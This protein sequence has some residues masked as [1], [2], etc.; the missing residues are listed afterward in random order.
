[1]R[2]DRVMLLGGLC[3]VCATALGA[4]GSDARATAD[5]RSAANVRLLLPDVVYAVPGVEMNVY[6]DNVTLVLNPANYAFDVTCNKGV[7]QAERWTYTPSDKDVGSHPFALEVRDQANRV[8]ARAT[9]TV[10]VVRADA[11]AGSSASALL[12]GDSLTHA[13]VYSRR[14]LD[15]CVGPKNSKLTLVGSHVPKPDQP[16]NRHEGYGGWTA[17]RFA[18]Y[19]TGVARTGSH[20]GCGS[21]FLYKD[22][23]G[24]VGLDF[25]RYCKDVNSGRAP[26]FVTIFLGCNDTFAATDATIEERIDDMVVHMDALIGAI[27]GV[28]P[29]THIGLLCPVPPA[30]TQDAFGANYRCGQTRWQYKRN[31]HRVIER[32]T[33]RY[34]GRENDRIWLIPAFVNLDCLHNFPQQAAR[35]NAHT[36]DATTRQNNGVHPAPTGYRQIGDT[37]Y[38]WL[39]ARL[40]DGSGTTKTTMPGR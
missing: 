26:D 32:M 18:T 16:E 15:L 3:T 19:Y 14:L 37:I 28:A 39:K 13:S 22:P 11:G 27:R 35:W 30:A 5:Q 38:C 17:K 21:P 20:K 10:R 29:K 31:Q 7:Q 40:A 36:S 6:F 8:I 24:K 34:G 23:Q 1:M 25:G 4:D 9:S 33:K 2:I 12:I